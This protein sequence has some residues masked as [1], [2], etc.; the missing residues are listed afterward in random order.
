MWVH[1]LAAL[2]MWAAL[3]WG[4]RGLVSQHKRFGQV[5]A[6]ALAAA[7]ALI[8]QATASTLECVHLAVYC[9]DGLGF[10]WRHGRLPLDFASDLVACLSEAVVMVLVVAV[11]CGWTLLDGSARRLAPVWATSAVVVPL[12]LG[13]ELVSRR[14]EDD[15]STFHDHDHWPGK[16]HVVL[17][18]FSAAALA[19]GASQARHRSLGFGGGD[20][21][22]GTEAGA[23]SSA[24]LSRFAVLGAVW[25]LSFPIVVLGVTPWLPATRQHLCVTAATLLCQGVALAAMLTLFLG[26]GT[27]GQSFVRAST[28]GG[29]GDLSELVQPRGGAPAAGHSTVAAVTTVLRRKVNVD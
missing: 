20:S 29:M 24:L 13:L 2:G 23:G 17:R 28:I 11:G 4:F 6:S 1:G 22:G 21:L 3:A 26:V 19:W 9:A 18:V 15:F 27:A 14:Y 12:Q 8:L 10:R 7:V 25:L 5:H 16:V